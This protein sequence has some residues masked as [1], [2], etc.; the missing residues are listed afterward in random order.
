[1]SKAE[2]LGQSIVDA[3]RAFV[4]RSLQSH[5]ARI[6]EVERRI[7]DL[8]IAQK[9]ARYRGVWQ[10]AEQ[11]QKGNFATHSGSLWVAI[12]DAP[13]RPGTD[14]WQLAAKKGDSR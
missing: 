13:G 11:Y 4:W 14:G 3:V 8:E 12:T 9:A 10:P 5:D 7:A 6:A 2:Q 1:M